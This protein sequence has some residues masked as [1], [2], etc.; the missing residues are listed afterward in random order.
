[1]PLQTH[2]FTYTGKFGD[3]IGYKLNGK[4]FLKAL[5]AKVRRTPTSCLAAK[6][7]GRASRQAKI[8]RHALPN[9]P[10]DYTCTNRLNKVMIEVV[11][12]DNTRAKGYKHVLPA[13]LTKLKGFHFNRSKSISTPYAIDKDEQGNIRVKT[14]PG[15]KAFALTMNGELK[16]AEEGIIPNSTI[17]EPT[18]IILQQG[19]AMDIIDVLFPQCYVVKEPKFKRTWTLS[20]HHRYSFRIPRY[21]SKSSPPTR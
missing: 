3:T 4:H 17:L 8:I 12:A 15:I 19:E 18:L 6:D 13:N 1:M 10:N 11:N 2:I 16:T 9:L 5:P 7:F 14:E 21:Q 20:P